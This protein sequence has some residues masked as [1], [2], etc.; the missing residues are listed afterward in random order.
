MLGTCR[1]AL[2][3]SVAA[4]LV[5]ATLTPVM[6]QP[7]PPSPPMSDDERKRQAGELT[8]K[9][10]AASQ[11]GNHEEAIKL[12]L[13]AYKLVPLAVLLSNVGTEYQSMQGKEIE[14]LKYFCMYLERDPTG[15]NASYA[16]AQV[17]VLRTHLGKP[18][19]EANVCEDPPPP[20]EPKCGDPGQPPCVV[21]T[22][23]ATTT[24]EDSGGTL[25][26]VGLGAAGAGVVTFAVGAYFGV[27]ARQRH[28]EVENWNIE[29][30]WPAD[31]QD[32]EKEGKRWGRNGPILM[33]TG[34]V[35][36]TAGVV[37]YF[38]GRSKRTERSVAV[39]P[40]AT[41]DSV[42]VTLGGRF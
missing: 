37:L 13:D 24:V 4:L 9:A 31:I 32:R 29:M 18:I 30:A 41:P 40:T 15:T 12:Y 22:T 25:R 27:K 28:N 5:A 38:V 3:T 17:K 35:V 8:K 16:T 6:A 36:A 14:A 10:I 1:R 19:N 21:E 33:V 11:A 2:A 42:G 39:T 7:A 26:L 34:G 20:P 23:D